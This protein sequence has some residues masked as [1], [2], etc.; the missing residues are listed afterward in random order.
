MSLSDLKIRKAKPDSKAYK[1]SDGG[2]LFLL[3]KPNGSKVWQQKYRHL[4]NERLLSNGMYPEVSLPQ[5][6]QKRAKARTLLSDGGDPA[7]QNRL[8]QT[9]AETRTRTTFLL[10]AE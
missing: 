9:E 1:L 6:R 3:A 5:A 2:G 10:V 4:G 8:D 7:V